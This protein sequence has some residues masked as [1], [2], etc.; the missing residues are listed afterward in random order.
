[1]TGEFTSAAQAAARLGLPLWLVRRL[2]DKLKPP[3]RRVGQYR[4][5]TERDI[6]RLEEAA[7]SAGH[8]PA[9]DPEATTS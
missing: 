1:M 4:A 8:L 6:A 9:S 3:V 7:A 2:A 5:F